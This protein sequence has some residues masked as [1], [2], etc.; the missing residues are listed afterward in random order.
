MA[1]P[2]TRTHLYWACSVL[3]ALTLLFLLAKITG[4]AAFSTLAWIGAALTAISTLALTTLYAACALGRAHLSTHVGRF[5]LF[6]L[7][8]APLVI[9]IAAATTLPAHYTGTLALL[10]PWGITYWL[11]NLPE[12]P[13]AQ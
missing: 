2:E 7:S 11:H 8:V 6:Q 13:P 3:S 4:P 10:L 5:T 1:A 12:K 9:A